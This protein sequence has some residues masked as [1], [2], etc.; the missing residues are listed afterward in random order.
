MECTAKKNDINSKSTETLEIRLYGFCE[1]F[2]PLASKNNVSEIIEEIVDKF[3]S[4]EKP[5]IS[6]ISHSNSFCNYVHP[7]E[8]W[9]AC[10]FVKDHRRHCLDVCEKSSSREKVTALDIPFNV[11]WKCPKKLDDKND[12]VKMTDC[13]DYIE[14]RSE[15][16][17]VAGGINKHISRLS[18]GQIS[19][20][21]RNLSSGYN[22]YICLC[23]EFSADKLNLT[24]NSK[25]FVIPSIMEVPESSNRNIYSHDERFRQTL[26][27]V[28]S[29]WESVDDPVIILCELSYM[30]LREI[31]KISKYTS[32]L[33]FFNQNITAINYSND[34]NKNKAEV[35][36]QNFVLKCLG[37]KT[38]SHFCKFGGRYSLTNLFDEGEF[39]S[40]K[41]SFRIIPKAHDGMPIVE[42]ILYSIP[43]KYRTTFGEILS[44]MQEILDK[45]F[46][47][48]EH[49]LYNL[50]I[51]K[52]GIEVN[53]LKTL[54]IAGH[55]AGSGAYNPS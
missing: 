35:Y 1:K 2:Y 26:K 15:T 19:V 23:N 24:E 41:P 36:L 45:H 50:I 8:S 29:I 14:I 10:D 49:L 39:F 28:K 38:Y 32:A 54:G 3:Y 16:H 55:F 44:S 21:Y 42:S 6:I 5:K 17:L 34:R 47:D 33:L 7:V 22:S 12:Y 31:Y 9:M 51:N 43:S 52:H 4:V 20:L 37:E 18:A 53:N 13:D 40:P 30:T 27:Q 48:V 11:V 46:V 25:I